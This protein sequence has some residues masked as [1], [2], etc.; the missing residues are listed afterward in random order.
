MLTP[1]QISFFQQ[2]GYLILPSAIAPVVIDVW[3]RSFWNAAAVD[4]HDRDTWRN[5]RP[6]GEHFK[7]EHPE[8]A[9]HRQPV[10]ADAI[11]HLGGGRF[12]GDAGPPLVYWPSG[13]HAWR[14]TRWG[15]VDAYPPSFWYPFMIAATAYAFDVEPMGGAFTYWPGSHHSTHRRFLANPE[16]IDGKWAREPGF[17]WGGP[18]EF[19][20]LAPHPP[21]EFVA[22]AGDV[23]LWHAFLV[24]TASMNIRSSPR[25]GFFS[26]FCHR[27][28]EAIKYDVPTNLWKYWGVG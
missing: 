15:H 11:D 20:D 14:P 28:Q 3:R 10:V 8:A 13:A 18:N 16:M 22:R 9:L 26:R 27:E 1:S 4:P 17:D 19:T 2:H 12:V 6:V 7:L 25:V 21:R 5:A 23:I 24:H